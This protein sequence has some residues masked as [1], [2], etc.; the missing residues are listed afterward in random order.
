M[1]LV[2]ISIICFFGYLFYILSKFGIQRSIS[3]SYHNLSNAEKWMFTI[4]TWGYVMTLVLAGLGR[5]TL[6]D[7]VIF[8]AGFLLCTVG[9]MADDKAPE[10]KKWHTIGA[11]GG[12]MLGF[13]WMAIAGY[14][15]MAILGVIP[16]Y[17]LFKKKPKNHTWWIECIAY[18]TLLVAVLIKVL[19]V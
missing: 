14:W 18:C 16:I 6:Q 1:L 4:F 11:E 9:V 10:Q 8:F 7:I 17:F 12:I 2:H 5:G 19:S 15:Y 3:A 13:I